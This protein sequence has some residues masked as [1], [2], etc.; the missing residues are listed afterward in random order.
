MKLWKNEAGLPQIVRTVGTS[1]CLDIQS[2]Y[3][4]QGLQAWRWT[5]RRDRLQEKIAPLLRSLTGAS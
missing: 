2:K 4:H 1:T 5:E 3:R